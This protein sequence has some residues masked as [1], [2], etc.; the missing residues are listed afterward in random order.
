M[1]NLPPAAAF[2]DAL[3]TWMGRDRQATLHRL[4]SASDG[5]WGRIAADIYDNAIRTARE[6]SL[7]L[8][9]LRLRI[10][11]R[12]ALQTLAALEEVLSLSVDRLRL[13]VFD[14]RPPGL[15]HG[16]LGAALRV[17][18]EQMRTDTGI[19]YHLVDQGSE[20]A[21]ASTALLIYRTVREALANVSEHA[22]ASTV[23]VELLEVQGGILTRV[24]DD[25]VGYDPSDVERSTSHLGLSLIRERTAHAG[26]WCSI[27]S[28][29]RAGATVEF[30]VPLGD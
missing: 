20:Q 8:Q 27:E 13:L 25:G 15:E 16:S 30:W 17:G 19:T 6:S 14:F 3:V 7:W 18:L 26:G 28:S 24:V 2:P 12:E 29:P 21:S 11:D 4:I 1:S 10:R 9:M 22:R 5:E 23:T